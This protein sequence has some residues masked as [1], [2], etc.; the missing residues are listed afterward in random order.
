MLRH[1]LQLLEHVGL[2]DVK[3]GVGTFVK[4]PR[5]KREGETRS[6]LGLVRFHSKVPE[7]EVQA[8][9]GACAEAAARGMEIFTCSLADSNI[10]LK[11]WVE[12]NRI[13]AI[14]AMPAQ[15]RRYLAQLDKVKIPKVILEIR[16][17]QDGLDHV[18]F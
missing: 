15:S 11:N 5:R 2:V 17:A 9:S 7:H 10:T 4:T 12:D 13:D 1:V 8:F 6:N 14:V 16:D 3:H 18:V